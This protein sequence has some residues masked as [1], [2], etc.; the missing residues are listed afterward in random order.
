MQSRP[1]PSFQCKTE[2][3]LLGDPEVRTGNRTSLADAAGRL[4]LAGPNT[5][6]GEDDDDDAEEAIFEDEVNDEPVGAK[7]VEITP[8]GI[9]CRTISIDRRHLGGET[10]ENCAVGMNGQVVVGVG[11][12]GGVW[13]WRYR[14]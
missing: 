2:K 11:T 8:P 5:A 12:K 4:H 3:K 1:R 9:N 13:M 6:E 14:D 7:G 10:L